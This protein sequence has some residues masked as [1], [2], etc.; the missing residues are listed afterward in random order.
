MATEVVRNPRLEAV[1]RM[2]AS[3]KVTGKSISMPVAEI[4]SVTDGLISQI[5]VCYKGSAAMAATFPEGVAAAR[6]ER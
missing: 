6:Q 1:E 5:D 4:Y 3:S 2:F